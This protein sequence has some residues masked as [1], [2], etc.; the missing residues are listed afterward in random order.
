MSHSQIANTPNLLCFNIKCDFFFSLYNKVAC[1]KHKFSMI[2]KP[3]K[4]KILLNTMQIGECSEFL[5]LMQH[6]QGIPVCKGK[7]YESE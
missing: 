3:Q 7:K 1:V 6:A 4:F 2:P 5:I